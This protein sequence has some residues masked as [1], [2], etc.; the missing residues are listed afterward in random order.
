M[1]REKII[2]I[3]KALKKVLDY[4]E[5]LSDENFELIFPKAKWGMEQVQLLKNELKTQY[6]PEVYLKIENHLLL[7]AK[8]IANKYDNIITLKRKKLTAVGEEISSMQNRKKI[9]NYYR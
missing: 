6:P 5:M 2:I 4:L 9:V 8:L 3:E 1:L 7:P